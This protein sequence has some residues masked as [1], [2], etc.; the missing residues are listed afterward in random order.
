MTLANSF[1]QLI[2]AKRVQQKLKTNPDDVDSLVILASLVKN[3]PALKRKLVDRVLTLEPTNKIARTMLLELDQA[4]MFS[5]AIQSVAAAQI[6][7]A[8]AVIAVPSASS[9]EKPL[10]CRYSIVH[11]ILVYPVVAFFL[12]PMILAI[13]S[14][15]V[16]VIP[17]FLFFSLLLLIPIWFVSAVAE[18][19]NTAIK[20]TRLFGLYRREIEWKDIQSVRANLMGVG[21][22]L[23]SSEGRSIPLSSQL[24]G[25][26]RIVE[27]LQGMR[28]DLFSLDGS[29]TFQKGFWGKYGWFF[30]VIPMTLLTPGAVIAPPFLPGIVIAVITYM[31][32]KSILHAPHTI[33]VEENRMF[34]KSFRG[35]LEL[36]AGQIKDISVISVRNRRGVAKNMVQ[37]TDQDGRECTFAGFPEGV[38]IMYGFLQ[39]WWNRYRTV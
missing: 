8:P 13:P 30:I 16:N 36:T 34:A 21:M 35:K 3:D 29:K 6:V 18:V 14:M 31:F 27:I 4:E 28:P 38:E 15:D 10:V 37:I 17:G 25:Y 12:L 2:L 32:W 7:P 39:N 20:L 1:S 9:L 22:K 23:T 5:G 24:H 11:Q 33:K 26:P 19:S